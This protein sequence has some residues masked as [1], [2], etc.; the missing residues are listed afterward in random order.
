[1]YSITSFTIKDHY[2]MKM[3]SVEVPIHKTYCMPSSV[4]FYVPKLHASALAAILCTFV[5]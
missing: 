4:G 2:Q 1:M 3:V 5:T